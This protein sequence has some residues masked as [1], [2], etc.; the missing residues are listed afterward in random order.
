MNVTG[1]AARTSLHHP[2]TLI[3][4]VATLVFLSI[5]VVAPWVRRDHTGERRVFWWAAA[6]AAASVF[7]A[8]LPDWKLGIG[9]SLFVIGMTVFT[10]YFTGSYIQ[11][12]GKVYAFHVSD[13]L[14]ESSIDGTHPPRREDPDYDPAPDS[15]SGIA[16]AGK[17]WW[18]MIFAMTICVFT[19]DP[20]KL[21][22]TAVSV[23]A[24]L[25]IATFFGYGDASWGY[26]IARGQRIQ[27]SII[28]VITAGVFTVFY[29]AAFYAGKHRPLRRQQSMEYRAHPRHQKRYPS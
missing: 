27:F 6:A 10:A 19:V 5:T 4:F 28:A 3:F 26:P 15:Y 11:I 12:R 7:F 29:L 2:H 1:V 16:T 21:W 9:M 25:V 18:L 22:H 23:F 14:P 8:S 17:T 24:V 13:S 20:H